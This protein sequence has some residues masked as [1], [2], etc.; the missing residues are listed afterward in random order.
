MAFIPKGSE[1]ADS[2]DVVRAPGRLRPLSLKNADAKA[3]ASATNTQLGHLTALRAHHAQQG[4]T[5]GRNFLGH[6]VRQ[7]A[8]ARAAGHR[9]GLFPALVSF[10]LRAAFPSLPQ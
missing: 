6:I 1:A 7:D 5:R 4:F 10:D 8:I 3:V 9:P 2:F